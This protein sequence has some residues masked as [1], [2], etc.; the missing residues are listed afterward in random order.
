MKSRSKRI[1][2]V[3]AALVVS[4]AL[5]FSA[6]AID[7]DRKRL[8]SE[9][10]IRFYDPS[11]SNSCSSQSSGNISI[12]GITPKKE[13]YEEYAKIIMQRLL[14]KGYLPIAVA[15]I[16]GN[17]AW[18]SGFHPC[19]IEGKPVNQSSCDLVTSNGN[20]YIFSL[21][22]DY[23][24]GIGGFGIAQ[25]TTDSRKEGLIDRANAAGKS[26]VDL[27]VQI[28]FMLDELSSWRSGTSSSSVSRMNELA[29]GSDGLAYAT[30]QIYRYFETPATS[31]QYKGYTGSDYSA[32]QAPNEKDP[33]AAG[34]LGLNETDHKGAYHEFYDHRLSAALYYLNLL[35]SSGNSNNNVSASGEASMTTNVNFEDFVVLTD[36]DD[37]KEDGSIEY[38]KLPK[39]KE[40]LLEAMPGAGITTN[41][42][43]DA[44]NFV[45]YI[46]DMFGI[47]NEDEIKSLASY[48]GSNRT[49]IFI[50]ANTSSIN[51]V[52]EIAKS[53][54]NVKLITYSGT[55]DDLE[56]DVSDGEEDPRAKFINESFLPNAAAIYSNGNRKLNSCVGT[57]DG[58]SYKTIDGTLYAFPHVGATKANYNK[59]TSGR[60]MGGSSLAGGFDYMQWPGNYGGA[61]HH[62]YPAVDLITNTGADT[63]EGI[64]VVSFTGGTITGYS[65]YT[66][67]QPHCASISF[68]SDDGRTYWIGH[69]TYDPD[70][71]ASLVNQHI[72][73]GTPIGVVGPST[74]AGYKSSSAPHTHI[75]E[76]KC[77][78]GPS[79]SKHICWYYDGWKNHYSTHIIDVMV[80]LYKELPE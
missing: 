8:F 56:K 21:K 13:G 49:L 47:V 70:K 41:I 11:G 17:I 73:A 27:D 5:P 4:L 50:S 6:Q 2:L 67:E 62:D 28:D 57:L 9:N 72:D 16:A 38:K 24:S 69:T 79:D 65:T 46:S 10:D 1:I 44:R 23:G 22:K 61:V 35:Q 68:K 75:D 3:I 63:S 76:R 52:R 40:A 30:W 77:N 66:P 19:K 25:W 48:V 18:E 29:S 39:F 7:K 34:P 14:D 80:Q 31:Y 59:S 45:V 64:P 78:Q 15:G 51:A 58:I 12:G 71:Y 36:E 53:Q 54:N 60:N 74:C 26:V 32:S 33:T 43:T 20:Q 42:N 55:A 37:L